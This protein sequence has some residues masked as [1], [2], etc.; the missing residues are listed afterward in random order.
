MGCPTFI[1]PP[2]VIL[3]APPLLCW[4]CFQARLLS[5]SSYSSKAV[6][7]YTAN[8]LFYILN[9]TW[10]GFTITCR[11]YKCTNRHILTA[12]YI[13]MIR[14]SGC[15]KYKTKDDSVFK[16][17]ADWKCLTGLISPNISVRRQPLNLL[18]KAVKRLL[19][20]MF[21]FGASLFGLKAL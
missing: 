10:R 8:L 2:P 18:F 6:C 9:A 20:W 15:L 13:D 17:A 16:S 4:M 11:V 3:A 21:C 19:E 12:G 7:H 14:L 1:S 5:V